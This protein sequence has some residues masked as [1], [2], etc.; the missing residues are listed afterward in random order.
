[1]LIR[2]GLSQ[3][4]ICKLVTSFLLVPQHFTLQMVGAQE[5]ENRLFIYVLK[6]DTSFFCM[7]FNFIG[8][9]TRIWS[10]I[11]KSDG[12]LNGLLKIFIYLFAQ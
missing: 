7:A 10:L 4:L 12:I 1:M 8:S 11:S 5:L 2:K 9:E 6:P 3:F